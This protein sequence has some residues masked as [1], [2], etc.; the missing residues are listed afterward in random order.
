MKNSHLSENHTRNR[1]SL[2]ATIIGIDEAGRGPWAGP[3]VA[4]ACVVWDTQCEYMQ[5]LT[6]QLKDSKKLSERKRTATRQAINKAQED[7]CVSYGIGI[8][9]SEQIDAIGIKKANHTAMQQA[10]NELGKKILAYYE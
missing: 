4:S 5:K 6:S 2:T 7:G 1:T 9:T 3:V 10:L 8:A